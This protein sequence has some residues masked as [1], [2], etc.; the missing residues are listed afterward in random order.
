MIGIR[1]YIISYICATVA[2]EILLIIPQRI[3]SYFLKKM[4]YIDHLTWKTNILYYS[5]VTQPSEADFTFL[6]Y[7]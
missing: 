2:N 7:L 5:S 4:A 3:S 1:D 6:I